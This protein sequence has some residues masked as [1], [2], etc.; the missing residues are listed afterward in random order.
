MGIDWVSWKLR[1]VCIT[2]TAIVCAEGDTYF[3]WL[4]PINLAFALSP[5]FVTVYVACILSS[6]CCHW[7]K[8]CNL[9]SEKVL[10]S[11]VSI[12]ATLRFLSSRLS[13]ANLWCPLSYHLLWLCVYVNMLAADDCRV[14]QCSRI[15]CSLSLP[16]LFY[17]QRVIK[18]RKWLV[19]HVNSQPLVCWRKKKK[20]RLWSAANYANRKSAAVEQQ[21]LMRSQCTLPDPGD[22]CGHSLS[23]SFQLVSV[24]VPRCLLNGEYSWSALLTVC[25]SAW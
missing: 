4:A 2:V 6:A 8:Q 1:Y 18:R 3:E 20:S 13:F 5:F 14:R 21:L 22:V 23:L 17:C 24:C 9:S 19:C 25:V 7:W 12:G 16:S 11:T 10:E 15:S